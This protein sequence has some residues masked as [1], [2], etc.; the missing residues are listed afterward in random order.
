MHYGD[1]KIGAK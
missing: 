1:K